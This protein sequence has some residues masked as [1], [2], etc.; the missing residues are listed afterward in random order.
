MKFMRNFRPKFASTCAYVAARTLKISGEVLPAGAAVA[1]PLVTA[2]RLEQLYNQRLVVLAAGSSPKPK[3]RPSAVGPTDY[4]NPG[5][6][7][8]PKK[9]ERRRRAAA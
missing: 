8:Q 2:R 7:G 4:L 5:L 6:D 3:R 1:P 9:V